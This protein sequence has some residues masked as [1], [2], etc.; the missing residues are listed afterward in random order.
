MDE[1]VG[2]ESLLPQLRSSHKNA[3]CGSIPGGQAKDVRVPSSKLFPHLTRCVVPET[4]TP[5]VQGVYMGTCQAPASQQV[6][7]RAGQGTKVQTSAK[8]QDLHQHTD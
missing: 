5:A 2:A 4:R 8:K 1:S 6:K 7:P 3:R